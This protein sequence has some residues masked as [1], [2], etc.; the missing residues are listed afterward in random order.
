MSVDQIAAFIEGSDIF[1]L[2]WIIFTV[3]MAVNHAAYVHHRPIA[4]TKGETMFMLVLD[5]IGISGSWF[6]VHALLGSVPT[7]LTWFLGIDFVVH[8]LSGVWVLGHWQSLADH[9][10]EFQERKLPG[11]FTAS[12]F[13]YEQFDCALYLVTAGIAISTLP[14]WMTIPLFIM[15]SVLASAFLPTAGFVRAPVREEA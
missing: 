14:L 13:I 1:K 3:G 6:V 10:R 5:L 2:V 8:L 15:L 4:Y 11:L 7:W 9:M 12:E